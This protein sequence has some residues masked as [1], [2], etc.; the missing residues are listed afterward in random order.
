MTK[1]FMPGVSDTVIQL[2]DNRGQIWARNDEHSSL[3]DC[4][5]SSKDTLTFFDLLKLYGPLSEHKEKDFTFTVTASELK[6]IVN[7]LRKASYNSSREPKDPLEVLADR[8]AA[9][10][11]TSPPIRIGYS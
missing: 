11:D 1:I 3:W 8:L 9:K 10:L 7:S 2:R 4:I 5:T 6:M